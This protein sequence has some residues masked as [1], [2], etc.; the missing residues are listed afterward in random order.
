[1]TQFINTQ[2]LKEQLGYG[3]VLPGTR[4]LVVDNERDLVD[5][6]AMLLEMLGQSV[7]RAYD[8]RQAVKTALA[9]RPHTVLL[10]LEMPHMNGWQVAAELRQ[11][12]CMKGSAI[13]AHSGSVTDFSAS[14]ESAGFT[15]ILKKPA[16][17]LELVGILRDIPAA[18]AWL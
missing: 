6:Q 18:A 7:M 13:I 9:F 8:G 16:S 17:L 1:M 12:A 5:S 11:A 10:D 4:I 2:P 3:L 15:G 14:L